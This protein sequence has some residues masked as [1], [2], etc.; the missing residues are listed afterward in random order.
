MGLWRTWASSW[1]VD[2]E[3]YL[4]CRGND[5]KILKQSCKVQILNQKD[6]TNLWA[7]IGNWILRIWPQNIESILPNSET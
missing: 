2:Y 5:C 1:G 4:E 3:Q 6:K 7:V